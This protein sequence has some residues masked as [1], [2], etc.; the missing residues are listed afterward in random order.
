LQAFM[1]SDDIKDIIEQLQ[2]LQIQQGGLLARLGALSDDNEPQP[3]PTRA[4]RVQPDAP[5][6]F[7]IGDRVRIRNPVRYQ[8]NRGTII[9]IGTSQITVEMR[10]GSKIVRAPP[11]NLIF[12][13]E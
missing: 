4:A 3:T 1:R 10:N 8:A 13:N 5:R 9:R 6:E 11:H 7:A 12:E 2:R